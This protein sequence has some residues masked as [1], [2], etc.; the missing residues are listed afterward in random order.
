MPAKIDH[1]LVEKFSTGCVDIGC[2]L[3]ICGAELDG[4]NEHGHPLEVCVFSL[5]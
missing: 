3:F 2:K 5:F 1:H 4:S